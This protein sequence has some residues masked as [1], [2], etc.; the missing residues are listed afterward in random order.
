MLKI[1]ATNDVKQDF[2]VYKI[3]IK[4]LCGCADQDLVN[5]Y[6]TLIICV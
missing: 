4:H 6:S 2:Y 3:E 5:Y 1:F